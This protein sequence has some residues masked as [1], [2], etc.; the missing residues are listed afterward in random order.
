MEGLTQECLYILTDVVKCL[1]MSFVMRSIVIYSAVAVACY[2]KSFIG[3]TAIQ[4]V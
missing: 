1:D 3:I 2:V 4:N